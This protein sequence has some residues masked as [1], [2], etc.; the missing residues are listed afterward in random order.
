MQNLPAGTF[1]RS[2]FICEICGPPLPFPSHLCSSV[3]R[4]LFAQAEAAGRRLPFALIRVHS[5]WFPLHASPPGL[6]CWGCMRYTAGMK[7]WQKLCRWPLH[8]LDMVLDRLLAVLGALA[9][10]QVPGYINHYVQRLAGHLEEARLNVQ[11]WQAI[12]DTAC[13]GDLDGLVALYLENPAAEVV[14]A[15]QKCATDIARVVDL[16]EALTA[17]QT[18]GVWQR[19]L[20]FVR[21]FDPTIAQ[22]T[23]EEFVPN[24]PLSLEGALYAVAG[25]LVMW[26]LYLLVKQA[27]GGLVRVFVGCLHHRGDPR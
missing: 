17:L 24:L 21:Q 1:R 18:A 22:Q 25:L 4:P 19:G 27:G 3:V 23:L 11:E 13:G 8:G 15:G 26:A 20:V 12:A 7:A 9:A 5:W 10:S 6:S 2:A 16:Q 14:A